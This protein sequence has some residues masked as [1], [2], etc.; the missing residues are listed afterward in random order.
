MMKTIF[1]A[2]HAATKRS[3]TMGLI[4]ISLTAC[5]TAPQTTIRY[6]RVDTSQQEF[7]KDRYECLQQSEQRVSGA[8]VYGNVASSQEREVANCGLWLSCLTAR[9]YTIDKAGDLAAP[10]EAVV[11]CSR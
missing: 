7:M 11:L 9:G 5:A 4:V 1:K 6:T 8:V 10:P 3:I 2:A